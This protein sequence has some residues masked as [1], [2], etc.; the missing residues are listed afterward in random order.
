MPKHDANSK[1][2]GSE[3][4]LAKD[5]ICGMTVDPQKAAAKIDHA[6]QSHY[7]CSKG[8]AQRFAQ[9]PEKYTAATVDS[10]NLPAS[11]P[12][13][14]DSS[15]PPAHAVMQSGAAAKPAA[16][17]SAAHNHAAST[18]SAPSAAPQGVRYTCPMHPQIVQIGP[19]SCPICGMA[20]EPMDVFAEVEADPEY[21]SMRRR[22][23]VSAVLSLPLLM[24][25]MFGE[26]LGLHLPP[27]ALHWI[28]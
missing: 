25:A 12:A 20:L 27:T 8:C 10:P 16:V 17:P 13:T 4:R 5:P 1:N 15:K 28:E 14:A 26:S 24:L 3:S 21:D 11:R 23:W 7:F 9:S 18:N 22:F 2:L 19:G 6:G